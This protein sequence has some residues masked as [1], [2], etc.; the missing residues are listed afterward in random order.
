MVAWSLEATSHPELAVRSKKCLSA[1]TK[2]LATRL[3]LWRW[4][5]TCSN[6]AHVSALCK[7]VLNEEL[8]LAYALFS[9]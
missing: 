5:Q 1:V 2:I 8:K 3:C 6:P 7:T 4:A 9:N